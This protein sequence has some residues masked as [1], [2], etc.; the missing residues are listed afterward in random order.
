MRQE[1]RDLGDLLLTTDMNLYDQMMTEYTK[2]E[3][4]WTD[5][6]AVDLRTKK[7]RK[8]SCCAKRTF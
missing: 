3:Y 2:R 4:Y 7:V 1:I 5:S 8:Y 6:K